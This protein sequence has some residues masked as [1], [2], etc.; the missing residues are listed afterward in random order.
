ML[1]I[2]G[3]LIMGL[4]YPLFH[5]VSSIAPE[6]LREQSV[7]ERILQGAMFVGPVLLLII[8]WC[9]VDRFV[10]RADRTRQSDDGSATDF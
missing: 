10:L 1:L 4:F 9:I 3:L 7:R 2:N 8:E 6:T 5:V